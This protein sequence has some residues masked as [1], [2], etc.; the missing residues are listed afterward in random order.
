[1][2]EIGLATS[3]I[4]AGGW[5]ESPLVPAKR[6]VEIA[7]DLDP[8]L[9]FGARFQ[10]GNVLWL[11]GRVADGLHVTEE[12]LELAGQDLELGTKFYGFS[13]PNFA[14]FQKACLLMWLGR[15]REA[16]GC[17]ERCLEVA[18]ERNEHLAVCQMSCWSGSPLE[19]LTGNSHQAL[20]RSQRALEN[21][22]RSGDLFSGTVALLHLGWAQLMHGQ[23]AEALE[24][25]QRVDH[26]HRERGVAAAGL[27]QGQGLLAEAHLAAGDAASARTV[28]NRCTA[29]RDT[30]VY[31][32]CGH[33][34]RSRVLRALDG[35]DARGEI[36][37]S[38]ARA[39]H[40]L[41]K[42]GARAFAPFIVEERARLFEVLGDAE[43]AVQA[44][45]EAQ[46]AF[47]EVEATG[48]VERLEREL[49]S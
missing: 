5:S 10:L 39:Q 7:E 17:L 6:A 24:S 3:R 49:G 46:R 20:V 41:E 11:S 27:N 36:E 23:V 30:W 48:H 29:E 21:A 22:E 13:V 28:A 45:R 38:L 25:L 1:M 8:E 26:L 4:L 37:A 47:A 33:L 35:A 14:L 9:Q 2:I 42:S 19:D 43:G 40:L 31:D 32:L 18:S 15:P 16:A 12:A 44:L 34:S